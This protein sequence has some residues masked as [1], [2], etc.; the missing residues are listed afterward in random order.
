MTVNCLYY[1]FSLAEVETAYYER[2]AGSP[3]KL[4]TLPD[5]FRVLS[6]LFCLCRASRPLAFRRVGCNGA[7]RRSPAGRARAD[8]RPL[9]E[10]GSP[11]GSPAA[12]SRRPWD[13]GPCRR[14]PLSRARARGGQQQTWWHASHSRRAP[15]PRRSTPGKWSC[16]SLTWGLMIRRPRAVTSP[17]GQRHAP[18]AM[19]PS[20]RGDSPW[21]RP[22]ARLRRNFRGRKL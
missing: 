18:R 21:T 22:R 5:G 13:H 19:L 16:R 10:P 6:T 8:P 20:P 12:S 1:G 15:T 4:K 14:Q 7:P 9:P 3:S 11:M 17:A 2:P